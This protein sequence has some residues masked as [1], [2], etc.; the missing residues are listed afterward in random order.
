MQQSFWIALTLHHLSTEIS[1]YP[2]SRSS[3]LTGCPPRDC[4]GARM[5]KESFWDRFVPKRA[6]LFFRGSLLAAMGATREETARSGDEVMSCLIRDDRRL[7]HDQILRHIEARFPGHAFA[8]LVAAILRADGFMTQV[9]EPGPDGG[10]DIL[11]AKGTLAFDGP[12]LCVQ[13]KSSKKPEDVTTLR[14]LKGTME[15]FHATQGLLVCWG[16]FTKAVH[17]EARQSFFQ[18][19]LWGADE[20]VE[21]IYKNYDRIP[22]EIQAEL[23]LERVWMLVSGEGE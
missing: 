4:P 17:R 7:A 11:A 9:A 15:T 13:V 12:Y 5:T 3:R 23:P 19:R 22:E 14:A 2:K 16:G 18:I 10:A 20:V 8:R 1:A 6:T 21:A